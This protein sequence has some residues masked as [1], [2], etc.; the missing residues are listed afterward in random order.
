MGFAHNIKLISACSKILARIFKQKKQECISLLKGREVNLSWH[1]YMWNFQNKRQLQHAFKNITELFWSRTK[2]QIC[3]DCPGRLRAPQPF[4]NTM[5]CSKYS[6]SHARRAVAQL[7]SFPIHTAAA[8]RLDICTENSKH[9]DFQYYFMCNT[10][11]IKFIKS[12]VFTA[13]LR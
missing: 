12:T 4:L 1:T 9:L 6:Q 10:F 8:A 7:C 13:T 3:A 5:C 11:N 2:V